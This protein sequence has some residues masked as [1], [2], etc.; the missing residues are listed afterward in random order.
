MSWAV[1]SGKYP[2]EVVIIKILKST[3][4]DEFM[5]GKGME[6]EEDQD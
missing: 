6:K 1:K 3:R 5:Y 2:S 4:T